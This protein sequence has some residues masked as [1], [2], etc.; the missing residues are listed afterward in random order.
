MIRFA[1]FPFFYF[2]IISFFS[3]IQFK[4]F[5]TSFASTTVQKKVESSDVV[6]FGTVV[7]SDYIRDNLGDIATEITLNAD[8]FATQPQ[9]KKPLSSPQRNFTVRYPGGILEGIGQKIPGTPEFVIGEKVVVLLKHNSSRKGF[10]VHNYAAGK[11]SRIKKGGKEFLV[12]SIFSD[13]LGVGLISVSDFDRIL[14]D[15]RFK[16]SFSPKDSGDEKKIVIAKKEEKMVSRE[17]G[18]L[19]EKR[20]IQSSD[21]ET[22]PSHSEQFNFY[23]LILIL[24]FMGSLFVFITRY[25]KSK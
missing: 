13:Q 15:F 21:E 17:V 14:D 19:Q 23:F 16:T 20:T 22:P 3:L 18:S 2:F 12:S 8:R 24:I 1:H 10:W 4:A 7:S 9:F 25:Q 6:V 5:A 11:F